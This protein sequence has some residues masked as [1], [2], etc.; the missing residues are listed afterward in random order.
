MTTP[1]A[2]LLTGARCIAWSNY[3]LVVM[4]NGFAFTQIEKTK[5][6]LLER[7]RNQY[8]VPRLKPVTVSVLVSAGTVVEVSPSVKI[9]LVARS[10]VKP[11]SLF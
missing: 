9:L 2:S 11:F 5:V 10:I 8:C 1:G 7:M 4:G 6:P 3:G